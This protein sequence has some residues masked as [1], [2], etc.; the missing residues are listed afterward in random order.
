MIELV[1]DRLKHRLDVTK[2]HHPPRVRAKLARQMQLNPERMPMQPRALVAFR[3]IGQ[4]VCGFE[5]ENFEDIHQRIVQLS[6]N[7]SACLSTP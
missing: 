2:I 5:G 7:L 6:G 4:P 3:H 1:V